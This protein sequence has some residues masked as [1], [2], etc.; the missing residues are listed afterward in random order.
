MHHIAIVTINQP[1]LDS[2]YRLSLY[3]KDYEI[4]IYTKKGLKHNFEKVI[5]YKKLDD[6]LPSLW[7][8]LKKSKETKKYDA[9]IFLL[10]IGAVVRKI[11]P[12]LKDKTKD[13]AILVMNLALDRV[14]P[15]LGGH[16]AGANEF[17]N[18]IA[19][20]I[21][22]CVNFIS[23]ATD[24]TNTL[25]FEMLA[26][27]REWIICNIKPLAKISNRLI[28]KQKVK[29]ATYPKI[30]DSIPNKENLKLIN[31]M[32]TSKKNVYFNISDTVIIAPSNKFMNNLWLSPPVYLGIGCNRDTPYEIINKAFELFLEE[33]CLSRFQIKNIASFIL[34]EREKGL[35][36][37]ARENEFRIVF[38]DDYDINA[39]QNEFSES[40][41]TK[42]FG[43]K[44]VAEPCSLLLSD[45][46]ELIFKK[47]VYF[48]SVTIAGAL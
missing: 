37:F 40:A 44:G 47:E 16:L 19:S 23:T 35:L 31:L 22:G 36:E 13:P 42:F 11:A 28:N 6:I 46:K 7:G 45:Y 39:L 17:S 30:F 34:K 5:Y 48:N 9:I 26:K 21:D 15:L 4:D 12:F 32:D 18:I 3:L 20:R 24:Q 14:V 25:S 1:S 2:A 43:I 33:H 10:A 41:S 8:N 38:Y 27:E 29:V